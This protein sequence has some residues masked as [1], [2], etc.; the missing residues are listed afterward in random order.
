MNVFLFPCKAVFLAQCFE[1][2]HRERHAGGLLT[3]IDKAAIKRHYRNLC[4]VREHTAFNFIA[5][6][7]DKDREVLDAPEI[8]SSDSSTLTLL[9]QCL[10]VSCAADCAAILSFSL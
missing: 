6:I 4:T 1:C 5:A 7:F 3:V 2:N 8:F 10:V 9:S